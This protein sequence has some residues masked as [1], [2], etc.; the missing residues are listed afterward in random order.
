[1]DFNWKYGKEKIKFSVPDAQLIGVL[2]R[3]KTETSGTEK[4]IAE[5]ALRNP[6][7]SAGIAEIIRRKNARNAVIVVN[8]ITR[9]TPY[10]IM[11][12][13][14]LSEIE[15]AGILPE[16]I[17]LIIATGIHRPQTDAENRSMYGDDA[18][19][20]CLIVNHD[21][22]G[23]V[24][25]VGRLPDGTPLA[26]NKQAVEAD[27]LITTGLIGLHYFAGYS[28]GRKSIVPGIAER[29]AIEASHA[30][31]ADP[32]ACLG[33][34]DDNPVSEIMLGAAKTTGVDFI[35][36]VIT[37]DH[38][39]IVHA[40]A[41]DL[42][43]AWRAGVEFSRRMSVVGLNRAADIV[44][45]G[46]GGFPKDINVYQAQ[47]A[48]DAA[49]LACKQGGVIIL[50]AACDEGLG[51]ENF[52]KWIQEASCPADIIARFDRQFEL[53]GHKA[54]AICRIL[55]KADIVLVSNLP[56]QTVRQCFMTPASSMEEALRLAQDKT[57]QQAT[58]VV[59]PE[60][61]ALAVALTC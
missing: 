31:M 17:T 29:R 53:G 42:E 61:P 11:L 18:V 9:P 19:D 13:P 47:K 49:V 48:L 58:I 37:D 28:G 7:G 60:A 57:G 12:P 38:K 1:M 23:E 16:N 50:A 3:N 8:D 45:A 4:E 5:A 46:C 40:V 6:I 27:L 14:L 43:Q 35:F 41:G 51:E 2:E 30:L 33:N 55:E 34:V 32:R 24:V 25:E 44:I 10:H 15:Q 56:D 21:P 39:K 22:D 26:V 59:M 36:N 52:E 54:Y 20:R